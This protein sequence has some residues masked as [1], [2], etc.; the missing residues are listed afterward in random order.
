MKR[1]NSKTGNPF[2]RGD[3]REDGKIFWQRQLKVKLQSGYFAETWYSPNRYKEVYK[4]N[5]KR[6]TEFAK[7]NPSIVNARGRKSSRNNRH[8]KNANWAAYHTGKLKRTPSWLTKK[9]KQ[10]IKEF[11]LICKMFQMYTGQKYHV[12]HIVPLRG[13]FVSGLHVPWNLTVLPA[14][15]NC[16]K[17]NKYDY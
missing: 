4:D 1:I 16:S 14:S 3:I 2:K 10:E 7:K 12:D 11:Y 13:E 6:L 9:H 8:T 15:E 17:Y 5:L